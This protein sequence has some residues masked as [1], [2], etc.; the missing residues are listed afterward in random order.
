MSAKDWNQPALVKAWLSTAQN[1]GDIYRQF[2]VNPVIHGLLSTG[3]TNTASPIHRALSTWY[4][5]H[6]EDSMD[7]K[8]QGKWYENW[9]LKN[10]DSVS[11]L[12]LGCGEGY[13]GR[14][15]SRANV[16]YVGVDVSKGLLKKA[17]ATKYSRFVDRDLDEINALKGVW[18]DRLPPNWI[19]AITVLDH[20]E[21]PNL[22]LASIA[23]QYDCGHCGKMLV[24]TCNPSF[25][26]KAANAKQPT[27]VKIATIGASGGAVTVFLRSR[28]EMR[29]LFRDAGFHIIDEASPHLPSQISP[30]RDFDSSEFNLA[31]PPL[32]F[33]LLGIHST[34]R[35]TV[36]PAE[37]KEWAIE[38]GSDRGKF[39]S[40]R[41]L[42]KDLYGHHKELA[43]RTLRPGEIVLGAHNAGG[44]IFVVKEGLFEFNS[45]HSADSK[46]QQ[47]SSPGRWSFK[48]GEMFGELELSHGHEQSEWLYTATV[49]A[50]K[51]GVR[52]NAKVLEVPAAVTHKLME[53]H[54][55]LG[56]PFLSLLR[57]KVMDSLVK[58]DDRVLDDKV[59]QVKELG[60]ILRQQ[61]QNDLDG[62][63]E[64]R[65]VVIVASIVSQGLST[66][67]ERGTLGFNES[68]VV[69]ISSVHG[70]VAET[71]GVSKVDATKINHAFKFLAEAGVLRKARLVNSTDYTSQKNE[72]NQAELLRQKN[73]S[74]QLRAAVI[75]S[76]ADFKFDQH[77]RDAIS[78]VLSLQAASFYMVDD[79]LALRRC[80]LE[81]SAAL[82]ED[83]AARRHMLQRP[84]IEVLRASDSDLE[85]AVVNLLKNHFHS[86]HW[87]YDSL[88]WPLLSNK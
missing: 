87:Q 85:N 35:Q 75:A 59:R 25:Y 29:R 86:N 65:L 72:M 20:L 33:W 73:L 56:N 78:C 15:L 57:K 23:E 54:S 49:S 84:D 17:S 64:G 45:A 30:L 16:P 1:N 39:D 41:S 50:I 42:L 5:D 4:R 36:S 31:Y 24:V 76:L 81:P 8:Q 82:F 71:L 44:R 2:L 43:W 77:R 12:D 79:E 88:G 55:S 68:P 67:R 9:H 63:L 32:N 10:V 66:E 3:G 40:T 13:R 38:L 26:G 22:L 18:T 47:T 83:L 53:S 58:F 48:A 46:G 11:L 60:K 70:V 21:H 80:V 14:W 62:K 34:K 28:S 37:L 61:H 6:G 69:F 19:F 27:K 51:D 7:P 52:G 74:K